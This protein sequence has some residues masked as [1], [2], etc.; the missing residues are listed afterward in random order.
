MNNPLCTQ[1]LNTPE[2][3][4]LQICMS[5][6][7]V[8]SSPRKGGGGEGGGEGGRGTTIVSING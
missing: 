5:A 8:K 6:V 1:Y 3:L 7:D 2:T 4:Y